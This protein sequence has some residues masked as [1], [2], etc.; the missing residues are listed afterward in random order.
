MGSSTLVVVTLPKSDSKVHYS[1]VGDSGFVILRKTEDGKFTVVHAS[2]SQQRRFNFPYQLGWNQ[3]GDHPSIANK[4]SHDVQNEDI[5]VVATD[6]VLDNLDAQGVV[7]IYL[8]CCT[9][10]RSDEISIF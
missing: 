9:C 3:N 5:L 7:H 4:G 10:H 1:Y 6:G 2:K 8:D